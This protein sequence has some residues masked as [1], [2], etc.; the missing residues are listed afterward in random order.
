V[1][2]LALDSE[3]IS[4]LADRLNHL[5]SRPTQALAMGESGRRKVEANYLDPAL[6]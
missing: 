2:G 1:D 4:R 6:R 5:R 3:N